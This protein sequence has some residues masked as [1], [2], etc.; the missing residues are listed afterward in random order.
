[1]PTSH[2]RITNQLATTDSAPTQQLLAQI[3]TP[4]RNQ[5]QYRQTGTPLR[6]LRDNHGRLCDKLGFKYIY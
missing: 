5:L 2:G 3:G 1:M 6:H 4:V